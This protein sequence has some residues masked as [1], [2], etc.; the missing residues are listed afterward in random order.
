[1]SGLPKKNP[2]I[3]KHYFLSNTP[4][5]VSKDFARVAYMLHDCNMKVCNDMYVIV[6]A[7][8]HMCMEKTARG[9]V[10]RDLYSTRRSRV[11]YDSRDSH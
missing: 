9:G 10:S 1:V 8:L 2:V 7:L 4:Q 6:N 3:K 5:G 11:L